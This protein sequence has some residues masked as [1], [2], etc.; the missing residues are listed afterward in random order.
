MHGFEQFSIEFF[1]KE[2]LE[3]VLLAYGFLVSFCILFS[4]NWWLLFPGGTRWFLMKKS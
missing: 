4:C 3:R 1:K 2:H